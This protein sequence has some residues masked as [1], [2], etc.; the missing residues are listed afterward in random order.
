MA[1]RTTSIL[2][3]LRLSITIESSRLHSFS[4]LSCGEVASLGGELAQ[5]ELKLFEGRQITLLDLAT[6]TSGLPR[7]PENLKPIN[8]RD[9]YA[10]SPQPARAPDVAAA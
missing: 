5:L 4:R 10:D 2:W 6:N 1:R 9:P 8:P 7:L 3:K